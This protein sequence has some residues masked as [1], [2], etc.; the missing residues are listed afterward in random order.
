[1]QSNREILYEIK[2][3]NES[4]TF[5]LTKVGEEYTIFLRSYDDDI[6]F[7]IYHKDKDF[8]KKVMGLLAES[9]NEGFKDGKNTAILFS[10]F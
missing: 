2:T 10:K 4:V 7:I 9:Y 3:L 8:M 1:M 6:D 5:C